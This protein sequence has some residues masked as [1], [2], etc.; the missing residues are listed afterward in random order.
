[1]KKIGL[2]I[3]A[4]L[5]FS[6]ATPLY[7]SVLNFTDTTL[8]TQTGTLP[9][10]DY[11]GHNGWWGPNVKWLS[12]FGDYVTWTHHFSFE[13]TL[14]D[15]LSGTLSITLYDNDPLDNRLW[16][17]EYALGWGEDASW[18]LGEVDP[19]TYSYSV[20]TNYLEDGTYRVTLMSLGGD[21]G[22][23]RSDLEITYN[24]TPEPATLSLLGLGLTGLL[25]SRRKKRS[26]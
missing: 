1:M 14:E 15:V 6:A 3:M 20:N 26:I 17:K 18:A 24:G 10:E 25:G 12:G 7:A 9:S 21:F 11:D 23:E 2:A 22:I 5:V 16:K 8:F 13:Q 4:L 19:I